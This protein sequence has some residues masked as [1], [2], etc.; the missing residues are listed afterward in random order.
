MTHA[1]F[2]EGLRE[3]AAFYATHSDA[4]LPLGGLYVF[5]YEREEF[6]KAALALA[7]DGRIEKRADPVDTTM[8]D[9]HAIRHFGPVFVDVRIPRQTFCRLIRPAEYECPDSLLE[10]AEDYTEVSA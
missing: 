1:E 10:A 7:R 5:C 9:Y 2:A 3:M 6:L 8:S 4:P